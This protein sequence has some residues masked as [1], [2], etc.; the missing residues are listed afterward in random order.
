MKVL[1]VYCHPLEGSFSAALRDRVILALTAADH[2]IRVLDLYGS[3]FDPVLSAQERLDYH[4]PEVNE[5]QVE[6]HLA[7]LRWCEGLVFVYPTWWYGP[8]AMLKGWLDRVWI[9]HATFEMPQPMKPIGRVLTNIRFIAA[10]STLGSPWWWWKIAMAEPGRKML[11][12]GIGALCHPRCKSVWLA[13]HQIDS[14]SDEKRRRF[15]G[16]VEKV[17]KTLK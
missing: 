12:K 15:L 17:F 13:L 5:R 4:T 9:P 16:K 2:E 8:P 6:D 11:L 14:A 1:I 3:G 7:Q 10:V